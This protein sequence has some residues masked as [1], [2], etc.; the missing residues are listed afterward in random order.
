MP[1]FSYRHFNGK[2]YQFT[3][4]AINKT[5]RDRLVKKYKVK[6]RLVRSAVLDR[7]R[8]K[9]STWGIYIQIGSMRR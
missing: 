8:G 3:E 6:Y 1:S 7:V 4:L 2:A 9:P 5:E